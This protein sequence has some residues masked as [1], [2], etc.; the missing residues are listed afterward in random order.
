MKVSAEQGQFAFSESSRAVEDEPQEEETQPILPEVG[1]IVGIRGR[2]GNWKV[3]RLR[4]NRTTSGV[5][6][7]V[8]ELI[9]DGTGYA[10][11]FIRPEAIKPEKLKRK[12]K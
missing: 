11:Y 12:R 6:I 10:E 9:S 3:V 5:A 7:V 8:R 4:P 1:T 2:H